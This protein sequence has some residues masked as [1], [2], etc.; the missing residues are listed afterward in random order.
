M[1]GAGLAVGLRQILSEKSADCR[2]NFM[3]SL[4]NIRKIN[5]I[6]DE[7]QILGLDFSLHQLYNL[8]KH[9]QNR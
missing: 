7:N 3:Y 9:P 8:E 1:E 2:K 4:I 6:A 5:K